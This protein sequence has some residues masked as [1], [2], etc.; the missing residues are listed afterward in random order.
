MNRRVHS[1]SFD[2]ATDHCLESLIELLTRA[3]LP[4][5]GRPGVVRVRSR[6]QA[7]LMSL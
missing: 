5:A 4:K 6:R 2:S 3:W 7:A 1:V